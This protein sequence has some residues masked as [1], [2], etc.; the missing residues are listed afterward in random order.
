MSEIL[1]PKTV[2]PAGEGK[3]EEEEFPAPHRVETMGGAVEVK[4]EGD[5]GVS[6]LGVLVYF[7]GFLEKAGLW[8]RLVKTCPLSYSSPNAPTKEEILGTLLLS[9]LSGH[10]RYAHITGLRGDQAM[11]E[12]VGIKT[13]RSED[14]VRRAF[15]KVDEDKLTLWMDLNVGETFEALLEGDWVMDLD[16]TVK[17]LYGKQEEARV[18]YNPMKPGRVSHVY[19]AMVFTAAKLV[20]NVDV[21][22]GNQTASL[23]CH[24]TLWGWLGA[25]DKKQWPWLI[26]GDC[27]HGNE[28][29][30]AGCE[31][32]GLKY[33]FKIKSSKG[34]VDLVEKVGW[35][36]EAVEWKQAGSGWE[37]CER[38]LRLQ[39][40]SRSRR[41]IVLRRRV[42]KPA[43]A[44][45]GVPGQLSLPGLS[46]ASGKGPTYEHSVLVTNW[47]EKEILAIAQMYR[48]RG[49]SENVFDELKNQWGWRGYSTQDLKRSQLMARLVALFFN[50][51]SLFTRSVTGSHHGE[52]VTTRPMLMHGVA[53][54]TRHANQ[55]RVTIAS[56]HAKAKKIAHLL[57]G[58]STWLKQVVE[59]AEQLT[60]LALWHRIQRRIFED[61][62]G[63]KFGSPASAPL[64]EAPNCRI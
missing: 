19:H 49:D 40:W 27:G 62:A 23:Y 12:R 51:W 11:A 36:E 15:E 14:S 39:G 61:F 42:D 3:N 4:W 60:G 8:E 13:L 34:V 56:M 9:V 10:R 22:A 57:A 29:M 28:N 5:S 48:D 25:R 17:T 50:W 54:T 21:Q 44:E 2:H 20:L 37:G 33:L 35:R 47:D 7:F 52:A 41:V 64:L 26:R 31:E 16:S 38:E 53:R 24:E 63:I 43:E 18:G 45:S 30:M 32:R 59:G 46:V 1:D 58:F 6:L 55:T